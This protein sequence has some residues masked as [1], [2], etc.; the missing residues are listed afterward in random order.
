[1]TGRRE[2]AT[3]HRTSKSLARV[4]DNER[5][6]SGRD[7][8]GEP[9]R[10]PPSPRRRTRNVPPHL[11]TLPSK[12]GQLAGAPAIRAEPAG[13]EVTTFQRLPSR[14][15]REELSAVIHAAGR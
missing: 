5:K 10:R 7:V 1:M 15:M 6:I 12:S 11:T 13:S 14:M 2:V 3:L 8:D 4:G 9:A